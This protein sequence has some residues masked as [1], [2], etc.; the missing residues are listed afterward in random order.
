MG[1]FSND[2]MQV[3]KHFYLNKVGVGIYMLLFMLSMDIKVV[4][5]KI[6]VVEIVP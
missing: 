3:D 2:S 1:S 6:Q 4:P 5:L